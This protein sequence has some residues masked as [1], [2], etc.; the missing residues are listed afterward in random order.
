MYRIPAAADRPVSFLNTAY[1]RIGSITQKL[2][3]YPE[4]EAKLWKRN[5]NLTLNAIVVRECKSANEV[6]S[7]LS[8]ETYCEEKGCGM[9][10]A[11]AG[12]EEYQLPPI[13]YHT[14]LLPTCLPQIYVKRDDD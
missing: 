1:I 14:S 7:L 10:K 11:L 13:K 2:I 4:K 8:A 3:G 6:V 5:N 12:V 9:D